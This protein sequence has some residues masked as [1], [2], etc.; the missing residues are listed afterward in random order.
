[1]KM[2]YLYLVLL[3]GTTLGLSAQTFR[4]NDEPARS[5]PAPAT[6]SSQ[7]LAMRG[8]TLAP[9]EVETGFA[10]F[11]ADYLNG[12]ATAFG[13]IYQN[14]QLTA[15]HPSFPLGTL[16]KVTRLD[17]GKTVTVRVNDRGGL[18]EGCIVQL[19]QSAARE[20]D[21]LKVG[22]SRVAVQM[23]GYSD[24]NPGAS[25]LTARGVEQ[26]SAPPANAY[27]AQRYNAPANNQPTTDSRPLE[28]NMPNSSPRP[29]N[30]MATRGQVD[31]YHPTNEVQIVANQ[32]AGYG[33]QLGAFR[34][35]GNAERQI[36][37]LQGRGLANLFIQQDK[38]P[39]G[40]TINRVI[41]GPFQSVG[42]AQSY[43]ASLQSGY[44]VEGVVLKLN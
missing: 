27:N 15:S 7:Q 38:R 31:D 16:L 5:N 23:T 30:T 3:L 21:L 28:Y 37:S 20:L 9:K 26:Q 39:D 14:E 29:A 41:T 1:M 40:T 6:P 22:K 43:L 34:D 24:R 25:Q 18:C 13:E 35:Y 44:G 4:W 17:N 12:Q 8:G 36:V 19:S 2:R 11:Y 42:H 32:P 33:V 10:T